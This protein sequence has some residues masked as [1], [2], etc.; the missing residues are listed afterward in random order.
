[1]TTGLF[2]MFAFNLDSASDGLPVRYSYILCNYI[3]P[4]LPLK[5]IQSDIQVHLT[6]TCKQCLVCFHIFL[7]SE[8]RVF[9]Q[10]PA[11]SISQ[12]IL[13]AFG[14]GLNSHCKCR[15]REYY[16]IQFNRLL[17]DT[18]AVICIGVLQL[19]QNRDITTRHLGGVFLVLAPYKKY[20]TYFFSFFFGYIIQRNIC[21]QTARKYPDEIHLAHKWV[22]KC[23]KYKG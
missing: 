23:F 21:L 5:F 8:G 2:L 17:L 22:N 13:I 6:H 10:G 19:N 7:H 9:F 18:Q 1:M 14:L 20:L 4:K 12:L 11:D 15:H 3:N 16:R